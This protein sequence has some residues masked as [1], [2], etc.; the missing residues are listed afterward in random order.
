LLRQVR[1]YGADDV[2]ARLQG[3]KVLTIE[4]QLE[5]KERRFRVTAVQ[6]GAAT[7]PKK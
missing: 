5:Q 3:G 6:D 1:F 7:A 4:G 2:L